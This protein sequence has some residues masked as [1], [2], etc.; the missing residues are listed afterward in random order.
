MATPST[1]SSITHSINRDFGIISASCIRINSLEPY[2]RPLDR[3][4]IFKLCTRITSRRG[5]SLTSIDCRVVFQC[6]NETW[7]L[8][9]LI[10]R[11]L[12]QLIARLGYYISFL[13]SNQLSGT[14]PSIIGSLP[15]LVQLYESHLYLCSPN[16][17][18][19]RVIQCS[20]ESQCNQ[21]TLSSRIDVLDS[22]FLSQLLV[23]QSTHGK[24]SINHWIAHQSR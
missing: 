14:I 11:L 12:T 19:N 8:H 3:S 1:H 18:D 23:L 20:H 21:S 4:A 16:P 7:Q 5:E 17:I 24:H 13:Y 6:S 22:I 2:H 9:P 10:R 15:N